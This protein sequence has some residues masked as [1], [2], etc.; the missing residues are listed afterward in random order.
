MSIE[1]DSF[2]RKSDKAEISDNDCFTELAQIEKEMCLIAI[3]KKTDS[4]TKG[5]RVSL[6]NQRKLSL[7]VANDLQTLKEKG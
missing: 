4:K 6:L 3:S 2:V 1:I 5:I 7:F